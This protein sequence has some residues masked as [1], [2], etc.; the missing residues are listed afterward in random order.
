MNR[1]IK[2]AEVPKLVKALQG[3]IFG[4]EFIKR[5]TGEVR[6]IVCR[7]GVVKYL[8]G[9][10]AAYNFAE[11][12]L[13]SVYDLQKNGYRSIPIDGILELSIDGEKLEVVK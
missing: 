11:K 6:H 1:Q 12:G 13:L 9:G 5:T 7:Q 4:A 2:V 8:R 10:K 3:R